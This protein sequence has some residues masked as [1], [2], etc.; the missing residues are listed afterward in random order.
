MVEKPDESAAK[1]ETDNNRS[2]IWHVDNPF[3]PYD[4]L[5]FPQQMEFEYELICS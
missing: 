1:T 5:T 4:E 2:H 3:G